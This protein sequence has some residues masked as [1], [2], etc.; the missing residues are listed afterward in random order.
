[1]ICRLFLLLFLSCTQA[2]DYDAVIEYIK[3][4]DDSN[5]DF[6]LSNVGL[7]LDADC[8]LVPKGCVQ[9]SKANAKISVKYEVFKG[10]PVPLL[11]GSKEAC[12]LK[13]NNW[14]LKCPTKK[15]D[16]ICVQPDWKFDIPK[17]ALSLASSG[18]VRL[19][20]HVTSDTGSAC[21]EGQGYLKKKN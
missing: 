8:K 15:D 20:V 1:M 6:K 19:V 17:Q 7:T 2:C 4:C 16:K 11:K 3:S 21:F 10:S 18:K 12:G 5:T 9:L 13:V 14:T